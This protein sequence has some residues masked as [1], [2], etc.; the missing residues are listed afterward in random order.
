V[1]L[2]LGGCALPF[3]L[4]VASFVLGTGSAVTTGRSIPGHLLSF[5]V[6]K[7]CAMWHVV[8]GESLC[9]EMPAEQLAMVRGQ[10]RQLHRGLFAGPVDDRP[11]HGDRV[12]DSIEIASAEGPD[13]STLGALG[14]ASRASSADAPLSPYISFFAPPSPTV[15]AKLASEP[16]VDSGLPQIPVVQ[17]RPADT[18]ASAPGPTP[19][20][21]S[22]TVAEARTTA[23]KT[24]P[25]APATTSAA[26][27]RALQ[28]IIDQGA[29]EAGIA[30]VPAPLSRSTASRFSGSFAAGR[31]GIDKVRSLFA[32]KQQTVF[33]TTLVSDDGLPAVPPLLGGP[34]RDGRGDP[35]TLPSDLAR[36]APALGGVAMAPSGRSRNW[37]GAAYAPPDVTAPPPPES[38]A[39]SVPRFD[40]VVAPSW[41]PLAAAPVAATATTEAPPVMAKP[42]D[43][44]R[45]VLVIGSFRTRQQAERHAAR[46]GTTDAVILPAEV[47]G[48]TWYRVALPDRADMRTHVAAAGIKD[49]WVLRR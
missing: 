4:T 10:K 12:V 36:I 48:A 13:E 35:V 28:A 49:Y 9:R 25:T 8:K 47:D 32:P 33:G 18:A 19:R 42:A 15:V 46:A 5:A 39:R 26:A 24:P 22:S 41:R 27:E 21:P 23:P 6:E 45:R 38:S 16:A 30:R 31:S 11:Q 14:L 2:L 44:P 3:P 7:D 40:N 29:P 37:P 17:P 34:A 43:G 1:C 20:A